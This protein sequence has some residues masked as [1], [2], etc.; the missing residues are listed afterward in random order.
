[1]LARR[2]EWLTPGRMLALFGAT[3]LLMVWAVT[4]WMVHTERQSALANAQRDLDNFARTF[5]EH[6]LRTI[7]QVDQITQFIQH[8]YTHIGSRPDLGFVERN[9]W[10]QAD[11]LNLLSVIGPDGWLSQA[12]PAPPGAA[13][14]VNLADRAH[15]RIHIDNPGYGLYIS[16]PV[17]GRVSR[18]WSIQLSRRLQKP[19]GAFAGVVVASLNPDYFSNFY[20][21]LKLDEGTAVLVVGDDQIVRFSHQNEWVQM[22]ERFQPSTV[23]ADPQRL[24]AQQKLP[25]YPLTV[26]LSVQRSAVFATSQARVQTMVLYSLMVSIALCAGLLVLRQLIHRLQHALQASRVNEERLG[27][28]LS[29]SGQGLFD[30]DLPS[31]RMVVNRAYARMLGYEPHTFQASYRQWIDLL[32]PDDRGRIEL[33]LDQYLSGA[34]S[35]FETEYRLRGAQGDWRRVQANARIVERQADGKPLRLVGTHLDITDR[36]RAEVELRRL[37]STLEA[38][39]REE[40][41]KNRDKDHL[42]IQQSRLASMGE[43]IGNIA[44]QWRQPLNALS[45]TLANLRDAQK[46][47]DLTPDYLHEQVAFGED[48]IRTMSTTIDDFRSFYRSQRERQ[49]FALSQAVNK[50]VSIVQSAYQQHDIEL[51]VRVLTDAQVLG[52]ENEY[53]Q[54]LLN[55]LGNAR[56]ILIERSIPGARV[57]L[58]VDANE[59]YAWVIVADNALGIAPDVLPKIFDPYFTTRPKGTGIGL[60]MS[61]MIVENNMGGRIDVVNTPEGAEFRITTPVASL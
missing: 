11:L 34:M 56:E 54:V 21:A 6:S 53:T 46:Y 33:L 4:A 57:C 37:N 16:Q 13:A 27:L 10:A 43:M 47:G 49:P 3:L 28:A 60:Y 38:R 25:G 19:D 32:H 40:V 31:G 24:Y 23:I 55:L 26:Y 35:A 50:A 44:H 61:K 9:G 15:F 22:G 59:A 51:A 52:V 14:P 18:K 30:V 5:A 36:T 20:R 1:M 2:R 48:I 45:L 39:V 42:M 58:T 7:N 29:S 8:E 17:L 41:N 12:W